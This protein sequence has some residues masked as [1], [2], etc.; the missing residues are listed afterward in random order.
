MLQRVERP[1]AVLAYRAVGKVQKSDYETVLAP[2]VDTMIAATDEV[3]VVYGLG[4]DFD[5]YTSG[6]TWADTKLGLSDPTGWK[7]IA[8]V[9]NHD[10]VQ[11][12]VGMFGWTVPGEVKTLPIDE[13]ANAIEWAGG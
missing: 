1:D 2:A 11:H 5:S 10:G 4:D 13:Q 3:R 8:V 9:T 7:R 6:A 12:V